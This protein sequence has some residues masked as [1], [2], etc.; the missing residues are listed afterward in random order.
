MRHTL[1]N[2]L[3][4]E[5]AIGYA[6]VA[7]LVTSSWPHCCFQLWGDRLPTVAWEPGEETECQVQSVIQP[8][9]QWCV[10]ASV[11]QHHIMQP[12]IVK[13]TTQCPRCNSKFT[14]KVVHISF[15][16]CHQL[17][18]FLFHNQ[19]LLF[20]LSLLIF[21]TFKRTLHK[22]VS[23]KL[24]FKCTFFLSISYTVQVYYNDFVLLCILCIYLLMITTSPDSGN[25]RSGKK[26][27]YQ[28][29]WIYILTSYEMSKL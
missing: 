12:H 16:H 29:D 1:N 17:L 10:H 4:Y 20:W 5:L 9:V 27:F 26:L 24:C 8:V 25:D 7:W 19:L 11:E 18:S 23:V 15:T 14:R 22:Y 21:A 13:T 6:K 2:Y 28:P 3:I